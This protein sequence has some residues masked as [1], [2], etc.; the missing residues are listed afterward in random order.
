MQKVEFRLRNLKLHQAGSRTHLLLIVFIILAVYSNSFENQFVWDDGYLVLNN[1]SIMSWKYAWVHFAIDL[2]QSFSNYYR[3]VQMITYMIDFSLWGFN[4]FGYHLTNVVLHILVAL[5]VFSLF[6]II[7]GDKRTAF[8]GAL[9]YAVHPAHTA[10][11]AYIAGRADSLAVLFS[12]LSLI[13][14]HYHF[15]AYSRRASVFLYGL[16]LL[17]FLAALLSKET[18]VIFPAVVLLYRLFFINGEVSPKADEAPPKAGK[19]RKFISFNYLSPFLII[20]GVYAVLRAGALNFQQGAIIARAPLYSR[21][22]TSLNAFKTY[23]GIIFMPVRLHM[24]RDIPYAGTVFEK[25]LLMSFVVVVFVIWAALRARKISKEAFFGFL[26]FILSLVPVMNI[27]PLT[28]NIAEHWLYAP[29]IGLS[30]FLTCIAVKF[31]D[32]KKKSRPF[33]ALL[34][35]FYL[36][37]LSYGTFD[38]NFDWRDEYTIYTDTVKYNPTSIKILNNLGNLYN[39]RGDFAKAAIFHKKAL[40]V[41][42]REYKTLLNL[43]IDYEA[44]GML[45]EAFAQYRLSACSNPNYG[46]AFFHMGNIY[47]QKGELDGAVFSYRKA[48]SLDDFFI[49]AHTNLGNTYY[50]KGEYEKA[51][52]EYE[53]TL[54]IYPYSAEAYNNIG[55]ALCGLGHY[56]EAVKEYKKAIEL[57]PEDWEYRLNLGAVYGKLGMFGEAIAELTRSYELN[58]RNTEILITLG[59]SYYYEG[60]IDLAKEEWQKALQVDPKNPTARELL[61]K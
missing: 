53:K 29:M 47:V 10:A 52:E 18:A 6:N 49:A 23:L 39:S 31:W 51:K 9:L 2:Y 13:L 34:A 56:E 19:V 30:L 48:I 46:K 61:R 54:E 25:G 38:R 50:R 4:P 27:Y 42:P 58:P 37:F 44:M 26:Y 35:L 41:N 60:K 59:A 32:E 8:F 45:D 22:L 20:L 21:L 57:N 17:A 36:I 16:S 12:L 3:P 28:N 14:F 15:K 43:G 55:S 40:K 24:E 5:S 7:T 11:V 33:I 1:P